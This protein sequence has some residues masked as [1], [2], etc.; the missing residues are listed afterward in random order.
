MSSDEKSQGAAGAADRVEVHPIGLSELQKEAGDGA[1]KG[2]SDMNLNRIMDIPVD[3]HVEL[4]ST[5]I[6][7]R[8]ILKL[9]SGAVIELDRLAGSPADIVVNGKL[10]G[11]GEVVVVNEN[12]GVRITKLVDPEQRLEV[13]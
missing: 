10:I 13:L 2:G 8:E 4:G 11:Q 6:P 7:I 5:E 12:F 3:V 1:G 9:A